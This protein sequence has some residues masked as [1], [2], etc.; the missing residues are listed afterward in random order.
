MKKA[1]LVEFSV[2]TRVVVE[3]G[4]SDE[5][6]FKSAMDKILSSPGDYIQYDNVISIEDDEE[7]PYDEKWDKE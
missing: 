6:I 4:S 2:M 7:M 3:D 1:Y 5:S